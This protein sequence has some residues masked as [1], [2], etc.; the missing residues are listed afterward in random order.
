MEPYCADIS[1]D[2]IKVL[3]DMLKTSDDDMDYFK[4]PPLGKHYALRWAQEDLLE[5]QREGMA[6]YSHLGKYY[7]YALRWS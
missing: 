6:I 7:M 1:S 3:D 4:I 5:E 2:D